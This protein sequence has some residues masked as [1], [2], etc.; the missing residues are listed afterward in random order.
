MLG[1]SIKAGLGLIALTCAALAGP[2]KVDH[3]ADY[4]SKFTK[5]ATRDA[6]L[7]GNLV[8]DVYANEIALRSGAGE[9]DLASGAVIAMAVFSAKL[10]AKNEP[11][12]DA[13]GRMIKD[14][15]RTINVMEKRTGWGAE[16]PEALRNGEWEYAGFN[17]QGV[18]S[19]NPTT[20]CFECHGTLKGLPMD[21]IYTRAELAEA[22]AKA[23]K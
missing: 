13:E 1:K 22:G 14:Q 21:F 3:P 23:K 4:L 18:K 7:G 16:Y 10:D 12:L 2:E 6:H 17:P 20:S 5:I 8:A 9:A 15:L 11:A 19:A